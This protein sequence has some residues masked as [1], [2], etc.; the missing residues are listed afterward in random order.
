MQV[1]KGTMLSVATE[2]K[3]VRLGCVAPATSCR[4]GNTT[5]HPHAQADVVALAAVTMTKEDFATFQTEQVDELT[6][7]F[8][9]VV[10]DAVLRQNENG[11]FLEH[12][13]TPAVLTDDW[14]MRATHF[15]KAA[16]TSLIE[17]DVYFQV[18]H[19]SLFM[20]L[21]L[22]LSASKKL[23]LAMF[24]KRQNGTGLRN[25]IECIMKA[26]R[27][28]I[29]NLLPD[30][31]VKLPHTSYL[32][33]ERPSTSFVEP[34]TMPL[35]INATMEVAKAMKASGASKAEIKEVIKRMRAAERGS[36]NDQFPVLPAKLEAQRPDNVEREGLIEPHKNAE[37][38]GLLSNRIADRKA[39]LW[40]R[41]RQN[42]ASA[43]SAG[44]RLGS[45]VRFFIRK[46]LCIA[47]SFF[48]SQPHKDNS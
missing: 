27:G 47:V 3:A 37:G 22:V 23:P 39:G 4:D 46:V 13:I 35:R 25:C 38:D 29:R 36:Y 32:S 11:E 1:A 14:V 16:F 40:R 5:F 48:H 15:V 6:E 30:C 21:R 43:S 28:E 7:K 8:I 19:R 9:A 26:T 42:W 17:H 41:L 18:N 33:W 24:A 34:S 12:G 31:E 44:E 20:E 45:K 2:A 10:R